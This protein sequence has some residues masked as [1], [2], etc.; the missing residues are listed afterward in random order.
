MLALPE[1]LQVFEPGGIGADVPG[2]HN[3]LAQMHQP[4]HDDLRAGRVFTD[5]NV[6][7]ARRRVPGLAERDGAF[8]R[9]TLAF[10]AAQVIEPHH[11]DR[12]P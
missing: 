12:E 9:L 2:R 3:A 5:G 6:E 10:V 8:A 4:I 7:R 11:I 1:L